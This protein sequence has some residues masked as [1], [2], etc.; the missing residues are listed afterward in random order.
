MGESKKKNDVTNRKTI[1]KRR[2]PTKINDVKNDKKRRKNDHSLQVKDDEND[3]DKR[4]QR[5]HTK[6]YRFLIVILN[7]GN[8]GKFYL[9]LIFI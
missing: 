8:V 3:E 9:R 7:T 1:K 6:D 5:F 4:K 2:F